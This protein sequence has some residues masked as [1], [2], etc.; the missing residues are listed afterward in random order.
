[1]TQPNPSD[2]ETDLVWT[3]PGLR[4]LAPLASVLLFASVLL[5]SA[6][7]WLAGLLGME[8]EWATLLLF[9]VVVILWIV[10]TARWFYRGASYVYRLTD[11]AIH[12]DFGFLNAPTPPM[13]LESIVRLE[14]RPGAWRLINVGTVIVHARDGSRLILPGQAKPAEFIDRVLAAQS[15]LKSS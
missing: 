2:A 3:G 12:A 10:A 8:H 1:M 11:R 9:W 4:G 7:P 5:L 14:N 13:P 15:R 6:G